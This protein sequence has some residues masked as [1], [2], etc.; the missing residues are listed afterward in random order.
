MGYQVRLG[1]EFGEQ[2]IFVYD[3]ATRRGTLYLGDEG[4]QTPYEVKGGRV[5]EFVLSQHEQAWLAVCRLAAT[6]NERVA[7][8]AGEGGSPWKGDIAWSPSAP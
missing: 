7:C 8:T 5:P 3:H 2:A 4:R 1:T 6:A